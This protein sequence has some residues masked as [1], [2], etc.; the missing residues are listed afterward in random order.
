MTDKIA[1]HLLDEICTIFPEMIP[2]MDN[3]ERYMMTSKME[4]FADATCKA[5]AQGHI[6]L[7]EKYLA[8]IDNKLIDAH[9]TVFEYI[10]VY[11]VEHLFW[12]ATPSTK[13]IG[14]PLIPDKLQKLYV[15]FHGKAAL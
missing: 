14:W 10:D 13:A 6:A 5:L 15:N 8:Y 11:Y 12:E 3:H 9:S 7:A 1:Q 4:A 2:V